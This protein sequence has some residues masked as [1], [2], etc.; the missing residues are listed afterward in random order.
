MQWHP[1]FAELLRPLVQDYFEVQTD[2]P[3]GDAPREADIILL[4]RTTAEPPPFHGVW[5]HMTTWNVL[6]FK[7]PTVDPRLRDLDLLAELGLGIDRRLNEERDRQKLAALP[8]GEVSFWF[9]ANHLGQRFLAETERL[10]GPPVVLGDGMW[11]CQALERQVFLVS[12]DALPVE[13]DSVPLHL[14]SREPAERERELASQVVKQPGFW[15][16][17]GEWLAYLHPDVWEEARRM[18]QASGTETTPDFPTMDIQRLIDIIGLK[19]V[20]DRVGLKRVIEE[21][22]P[23]QVVNEL[24]LDAL[25]SQ[26]TP[27]QREELK[28]RLG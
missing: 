18:A 16:L 12:R 23:K 21:V 11:R 6:E 1:V 25:V 22:G 3:V 17:Y 27:E 5:R 14:V 10:L 13:H 26:L 24:G 8:R 7:G 2:V 20:I 4:R 9:L 28:R 19:R 15:K